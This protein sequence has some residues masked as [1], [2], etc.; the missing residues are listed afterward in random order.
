MVGRNSQLAQWAASN[1]SPASESY[2]IAL[3]EHT[4][5]IILKDGSTATE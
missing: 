4:R 2:T 1:A 5:L 3:Q